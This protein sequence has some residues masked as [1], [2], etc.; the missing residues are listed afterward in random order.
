MRVG[1]ANHHNER[2]GRC[3]ARGGCNL[4]RH[5]ATQMA[6]DALVILTAWHRGIDV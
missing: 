3:L 5:W 2:L 1:Q 6:E 4:V